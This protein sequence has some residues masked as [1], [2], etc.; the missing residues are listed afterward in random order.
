M[1]ELGF[2]AWAAVTV[3]VRLSVVETPCVEILKNKTGTTRDV[4]FG[5]LNDDDDDDKII[6][7]QSCSNVHFARSLNRVKSKTNEKNALPDEI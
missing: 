3:S 4:Y 1:Y 5:K 6:Q 7:L 2:G